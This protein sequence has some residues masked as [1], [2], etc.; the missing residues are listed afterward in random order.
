MADGFNE[1]KGE[2]ILLEIILHLDLKNLKV[3]IFF[4]IVNRECCTEKIGKVA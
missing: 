3:L 1:M 4:F 2:I